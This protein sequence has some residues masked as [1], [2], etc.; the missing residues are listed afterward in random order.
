MP[1][2]TDPKKT[3]RYSNEF[4]VKAAQLSLIDKLQVKQVAETGV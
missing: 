2:Y 4:K 1:K 3:W